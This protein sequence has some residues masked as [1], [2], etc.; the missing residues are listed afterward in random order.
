[1]TA[2]LDFGV[3][4][5]E[6]V[7]G[8]VFD[9]EVDFPAVGQATRDQV[10][11]DFF[12]VIN[13]DVFIDQLA[14][15][16]VVRPT[17][18]REINAVMDHGLAFHAIANARLDQKLRHPMLHQARADASLAIGAAPVFNDDGVNAGEMKEVREHQPGRA[19]AHDAN[20]S[21]HASLPMSVFLRWFT[22]TSCTRERDGT[23]NAWNVWAK[24]QGV[25]G[26]RLC[27]PS[28]RQARR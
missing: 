22:E 23:G 10:G 7:H 27:P 21:A 5:G 14:E 25:N 9:V 1:M 8:G 19:G 20:L 28:R 18:E 13:D 15:I 26:S 3:L 4:A 17:I 12:L 24:T 2:E 6:V 11:H 16:D